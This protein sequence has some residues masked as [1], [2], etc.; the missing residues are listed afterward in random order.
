[1]LQTCENEHSPKKDKTLKSE[2]PIYLLR[3][4]LYRT[5]SQNQLTFTGKTALDS[6]QTSALAEQ[7]L[8]VAKEVESLLASK[9][10]EA[11]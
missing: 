9:E 8:S 6:R 3:S 4:L 1:M 11:R 5:E 10:E 7:Y 2:K